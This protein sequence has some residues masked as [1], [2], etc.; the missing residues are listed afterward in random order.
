MSD[1][2]INYRSRDAK[3]GAVATYELLAARF[4]ADR[5]FLDNQSIILGTGYPAQ[6]RLALESMRVLLVLIG[7]RWL[8][9]D[10]T[11]QQRLPIER[12]DDWVRYEIRRVLARGTSIVP[13][14]LDG[15]SLSAA[16][17]LPADV[18]KL[19]H[20]QA[21]EIRHRSLGRDVAPGRRPRTTGVDRAA[22]GERRL[23]AASGAVAAPAASPGGAH[24]RGARRRRCRTG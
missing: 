5:V 12:D 10:A 3:Y 11:D 15:A 4:G 21:A 20:Y 9:P 18:R 14:L 8:V 2:F 1:I 22:S 17:R 13:V 6:L 24:L 16:S 7:P 23:A 19:V